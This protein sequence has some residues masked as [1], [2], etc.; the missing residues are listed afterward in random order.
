MVQYRFIH[1][2]FSILLFEQ[3]LDFTKLDEY[4]DWFIRLYPCLQEWKNVMEWTMEENKIQCETKTE[5]YQTLCIRN[6]ENERTFYLPFL[7]YM[8]FYQLR[9]IFSL[10]LPLDEF[11]CYVT[12]KGNYYL[13]K[14]PYIHVPKR[15]ECRVNTS[16]Y[17]LSIFI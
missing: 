15:N 5:G 9:T 3:E 6:S 12:Y 7:P 16:T 11:E 17:P 2:E 14:H 13:P 10:L 8:T 1:N 4:I